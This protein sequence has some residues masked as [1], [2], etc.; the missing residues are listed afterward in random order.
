M[1]KIFAFALAMTLVVAFSSCNNKK[2]SNEPEQE[3]YIDPADVPFEN[4]FKIVTNYMDPFGCDIE[5]VA[6]DVQKPFLWDIVH[7][8]DINGLSD[9]EIA[10]GVL[11]AIQAYIAAVREATGQQL[12]L[13]DFMDTES[14]DESI[15]FCDPNKDYFVVAFYLDAEFLTPI[16]TEEQGVAK[17]RFHTKNIT[18]H[19][20]IVVPYGKYVND[21]EEEEGYQYDFWGY[22]SDNSIWF[23]FYATTPLVNGLHITN[24][25]LSPNSHIDIP[26]GEIDPKTGEEIWLRVYTYSAD[27]NVAINAEGHMTVTG[28]FIAYNGVEYTLNYSG[29]EWIDDDEEGGDDGDDEEGG[30]DDDDDDDDW[31]DDAP[32]RKHAPA[33]VAPA[34]AA[35]ARK[36]LKF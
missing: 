34:K 24:E 31:G 14:D 30:G 16:I 29:V 10:R 33:K 1:K 36:V 25:N 21:E 32:A 9:L 12:P 19:E 27:L 26:T 17:K 11:D 6:E 3:E 18:E 2:N 7:A 20:T 4:G 35:P 23:D 8:E 28:K 22:N 15:N 13:T 5:I